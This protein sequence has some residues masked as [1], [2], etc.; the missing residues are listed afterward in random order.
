MIKLDLALNFR[1]R[2][3]YHKTK[4]N[5]IRPFSRDLWTSTQMHR[6]WYNSIDNNKKN[7]LSL[8]IYDISIYSKGF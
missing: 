7:I 2:F 5:P 8:S 3:I 1:Q 4:Q 6:L